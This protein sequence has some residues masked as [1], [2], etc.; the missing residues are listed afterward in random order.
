MHLPTL[1][2]T[3]PLFLLLTILSH[4]QHA[5]T[6]FCPECGVTGY[7]YQ[8]PFCL[9]ITYIAPNFGADAGACFEIGGAYSPFGEEALCRSVEIDYANTGCEGTYVRARV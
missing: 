7:F 3:L 1:P 5:S 8:H 2:R 9:N 6:T 4:L